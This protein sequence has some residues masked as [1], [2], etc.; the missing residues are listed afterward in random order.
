MAASVAFSGWTAAEIHV[1]LNEPV[2]SDATA[3]ALKRVARA[4]GTRDG[5]GPKDTPWLREERDEEGRERHRQGLEQGSA[6]GREQGS[7][8][9]PEQGSA[10]PRAGERARLCHQA[11]RKFH[12]ATAGRLVDLPADAAAPGAWRRPATR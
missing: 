8:Q 10:K 4:L 9:G 2:R 1:A 6:Q 7:A 12:D 11:A 3:H 5:T